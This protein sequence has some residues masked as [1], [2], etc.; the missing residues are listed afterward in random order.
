L[1]DTNEHFVP[2]VKALENQ[3]MNTFLGN[4]VAEISTIAYLNKQYEIPVYTQVMA[5]NHVA[6]IVDT[7][8]S[9]GIWYVYIDGSK[10][11]EG[12]YV[13]YLLIYPKGNKTFISF[14]LEFN[15]TNNTT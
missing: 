7:C 9:D 6:N 12:A 13:N 1:N 10:S 2:S 14:R 8:E 4:F 3:G 5:S 11:S 15:C